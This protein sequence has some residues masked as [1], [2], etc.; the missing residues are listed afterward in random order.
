PWRSRSV[1]VGS[2][3]G[4][5]ANVLVNVTSDP[6][7][8]ASGIVVNGTGNAGIGATVSCL[9]HTLTSGANGSFSVS[10]LPTV[11]GNISCAAAFTSQDGT[12][13]A[14][15]SASKPPVRGGITDVG[16]IVV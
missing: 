4:N 15:V 2:N 13:L 9:G 3:L 14:G 7:T 16:T 10:G 6:L 1:D 5:A 8:A 11:Q 12:P